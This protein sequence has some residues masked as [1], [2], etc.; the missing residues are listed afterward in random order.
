MC[1]CV[2][3]QWLGQCKKVGGGC[4]HAGWAWC[5]TQGDFSSHR[6]VFPQHWCR[7]HEGDIVECSLIAC[8]SYN[9]NYYTQE[10]NML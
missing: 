8:F 7:W 9:N 4:G 5:L 1:M 3:R 6:E 10:K 2:C